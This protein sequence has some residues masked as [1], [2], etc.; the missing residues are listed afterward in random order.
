VA[1]GFLLV[2]GTLVLYS[3]VRGHDFINYDDHEYVV[4]NPHV[5]AGLTWRTIRWSLTSREQSNWHPLTWWSHAL[6]YELFGPD[7]GDH[8]LTSVAI[9]ALNALLLFLLLLR[10]GGAVTLSFVVAALFAWHSFN[11]QSVAWVA[12][13][14]N[15]L[16]A[17]FFLLTLGA[18]GWYARHPRLKSFAVVAG[19]FVLA[20]ASKPMAV[21]LPFVLLLLDYWPLQRIAGWIEPSSQLAQ[22][23]EPI[24]RLLLEKLP[25]FALSAASSALTVWAQRTGG[26]RSLQAFPFGA[27]LENALYSYL[28]YIWKTFW[29]SAFALFYPHPG[30][31]LPAWKP[32]L[33]AVLL[34]AICIAV[35]VQRKNHP[36]LIV[37]W[38]WF[39][40]TLF[41]TIGVIQVGDQA[42]AD[43]Y[44]YLPII[45]LFLIAVWGAVD[46]FDRWH[47]PKWARWASAIVILAIVSSITFQQLTYW[48]DSVAIWSHTLEVTARNPLAEKKLAL[49]LS[50]RGDT[51]AAIAHFL[52]AEKLDPNDITDHVTLGVL[53]ASRGNLPDGMQEFQTVVRLTDG[54]ELTDEDRKLR[55]SALLDLGFAYTT[56]KDYAGA[57]TSFRGANQ[58]E[59]E[60]LDRTLQTLNRSLAAQPSEGNY[61]KLSLIMRAQGKGRE[62]ASVL[63]EAIKA[64]PRYTNAQELLNFLNSRVGTAAQK[65]I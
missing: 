57:L 27:R 47:A 31:L 42:M 32:L 50:A 56:S 7:A 44:A 61:M 40:G 22:P 39:L 60:L 30:I 12:E 62:A 51:E 1:L 9:H 43:R 52:D 5:T 4:D 48:E 29:P 11:L 14:K 34:C 18:Y 2:A 35:W 58:S 41:P 53:Y 33:A 49:A 3:P 65:P 55:C 24:G 21:T 59:P 54:K 10:A 15:L 45:G 20:L 28:I 13:R 38:L 46:F 23:Q 25:L 6:D 36:Y 8:H 17:F 19:V 37:G 26:W 16:S 64:D 63:E